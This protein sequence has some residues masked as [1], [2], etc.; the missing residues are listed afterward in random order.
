MRTGTL[1]V[2][3]WFTVVVSDITYRKVANGIA[4]SKF[5]NR[6]RDNT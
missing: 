1:S 6:N 3:D 2:M 5:S 4:V